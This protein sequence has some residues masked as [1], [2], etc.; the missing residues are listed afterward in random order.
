MTFDEG[1]IITYAHP[2]PGGW[3]EKG[4]IRDGMVINQPTLEDNHDRYVIHVREYYDGDPG[5]AYMIRP[6]D[7][8]SRKE[9]FE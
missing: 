7:V 3:S 8:I 5:P 6:S 2:H 9:L 1:D 4:A